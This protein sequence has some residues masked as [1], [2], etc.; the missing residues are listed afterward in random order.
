MADKAPSDLLTLKKSRASLTGA[1]TKLSDRL[2][3]IRSDEAA[4]IAAI[5]TVDVNQILTSLQRTENK[6]QLSME[7]GQTFC[8]TDDGY[9]DF[10][11]REESILEVF[12]TNITAIR[13]QARKLLNL[14]NILTGL[15][16]LTCDISAIES[17][18]TEDSNSVHSS[19]LH[20]LESSFSKL[21]MD[22]REYNLPKDHHLKG[23]LD[24]VSKTLMNLTAKVV[25]AEHSAMLTSSTSAIPVSSSR[26]ERDRTKLPAI[27][28]PTF[29]GDIL[30]W[31]TFWQKFSAAV[32][33][34]DDLP[35]STKLCYLRTAIQDPEAEIIL[36]PSMDGPS[37]YK[38]LV[39]ELHQR[40][41]RTK[42]IHRELV[43]KFITLPSAKH[44]SKDLRRLVDATTNCVEC[45][46]A[47]G[48]FTM[49][50]F[51]SS[52]VYSKLPY[53]LQID[54]DN[55]HSDENKVL[56]YPR[57][58]EYVSKKAFTLSDHK[59]S[60]PN[61]LEPSEKKNP[62]NEQKK[63][64]QRQKSYVHSVTTPPAAPA[65][66]RP[67]YKWE[68]ALCRPEKHPLHTCSKWMGYT[69]AQRMDHV[70]N[71]NLC[72]N[73]LAVGHS[74]ASCKS[75]YR[76]RDCQQ[77]HHTTLHQPSAIQVNSTMVQ[78]Q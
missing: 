27:A 53:K 31:P 76:C 75:T 24:A 60:A 68:C 74:T 14:S 8:P 73:C 56:P 11:E 78:S 33:A 5:S 59:T 72:S 16:D 77:A 49:E 30:Q 61:I 35:D 65:P 67:P 23:E 19:S 15:S 55:D 66:P 52:L 41:E 40:Y 42:K 2:K 45:L 62:R 12:D 6:I 37:T 20:S 3:A 1:L 43:E 63:Q 25:N 36:N 70:K 39:K 32:D 28:L 50:A 4:A 57:L 29:K 69:L 17:S 46:E 21:R 9:E 48:L 54:W 22:W 10:Q 18:L 34:H 13:G 51:I 64:P 71:K 38:R 26:V 47:T 58:L 7:H 44:N